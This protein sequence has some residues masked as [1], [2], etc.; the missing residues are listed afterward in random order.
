M[1]LSMD[2]NVA[3]GAGHTDIVAG[4]SACCRYSESLGQGDHL[5]GW[6]TGRLT[7]AEPQ[8]EGAT[9]MLSVIAVVAGGIKKAVCP[10]ARSGSP[11][12]DTAEGNRPQAVFNT[13]E[14]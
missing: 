13:H 12:S 10:S 8:G 5:A 6:R 7:A 3:R 2:K 4:S 14:R 11:G 1:G 9:V